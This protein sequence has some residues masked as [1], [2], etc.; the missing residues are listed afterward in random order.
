VKLNRTSKNARCNSKDTFYIFIF[1]ALQ[2][3]T[4]KLGG[5]AACTLG[6][7]MFLLGKPQEERLIGRNNRK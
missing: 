2:L 1:C 6:Q 3:V 5:P 7:E 4:I